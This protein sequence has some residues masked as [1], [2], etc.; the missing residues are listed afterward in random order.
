MNVNAILILM[1]LSYLSSAS[2]SMVS[3]SAVR[4]SALYHAI[5]ILLS[6]IFF[7]SV[8]HRL[9]I[10]N[11]SLQLL[12]PYTLA[13]VMGSLTGVRL[14]MKFEEYFSIT[15]GNDKEKSDRTTV[16]VKKILLFILGCCVVGTIIKTSQIWIPT[17]IMVLVLLDNMFFS[18]VRR[19]RNTDNAAYHILAFSLHGLMWFILFKNL[20]LN[21]MALVLFFPYSFGSVLG[22]LIG[23][24][25]SLHIEK[26]LGA[27][28]DGH[29]NRSAINIIP[30]IPLL[31]LTVAASVILILTG[32]IYITSSVLFLSLAQQ[33]V[34][35]IVSRSR[36]RSN[37]PY[38]AIASI[39]SN[40]VWFLTFRQLDSN[41]WNWFQFIP[42]TIG[43]VIGSISGVTISMLIE[44]YFNITADKQPADFVTTKIANKN[45]A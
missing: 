34:F 3:R 14:S 41:G 23:Q 30:K 10:G 32:N 26:F 35:S 1:A 13:T 45:R 17:S 27:S 12:L 15:S 22:G 21:N 8:L 19:S 25:L 38:V 28:I 29:L 40:G 7:Y 9:K 37:I 33:I 16:I 43:G 18:L 42:Y 36:T 4:N 39:F 11:L 6:N 5:A 2:Y 44:K 31:V 24:N 20:S